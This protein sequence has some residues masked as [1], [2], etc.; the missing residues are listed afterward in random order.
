[1]NQDAEFSP[2]SPAIIPEFKYL[3]ATNETLSS[4]RLSKSVINFLS[5]FT[6]Y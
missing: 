4:V 5:A 6:S 3:E 1:V 2:R